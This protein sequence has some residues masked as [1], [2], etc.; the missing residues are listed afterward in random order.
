MARIWLRIDMVGGD[1]YIGSVDSIFDE[2]EDFMFFLEE[3]AYLGLKIDNVHK[4]IDKDG[5]IELEPLDNETSLYKSS[6]II[7]NTDNIL[8]IKFLKEDTDIVK[9]LNSEIESKKKPVNLQAKNILRF[10]PKNKERL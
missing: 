4:C 5:K 3:Q 9:K 10:K 2:N 1:C 8:T 7:M 6:M